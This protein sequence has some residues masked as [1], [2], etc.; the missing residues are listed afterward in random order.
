MADIYSNACLTLA[1][2]NSADSLGGCYSVANPKYCSRTWNFVGPNNQPF[3]L[4]TRQGI[5]HEAFLLRQLPL[6]S[7]GW[8]L[9]ERLLSQ[10]IIHF[11]KEE[12]VWE[13][14]QCLHCECSELPSRYF[15]DQ[16]MLLRT[17]QV[18]G[19]QY[20]D[21]WSV[22][23]EDY[24]ALALTHAR[25]IFPALQGMAK[26]HAVSLGAYHA[27]L[28]R[29]TMP[30]SLTWRSKG[31]STRPADWRAPSW[32]WASIV[33]PVESHSRRNEILDKDEGTTSYVSQLY[34][35]TVPKGHDP[36]GELVAG[37]LK[38]LARVISG[39]VI[40]TDGEFARRRRYPLRWEQP[41]S[42]EP[43]TNSESWLAIKDSSSKD[44]VTPTP[45]PS[46]GPDYMDLSLRW[47][48]DIETPGQHHVPAGSDVFLVKIIEIRK[49]QSFGEVYDEE[50]RTIREARWLIVRSANDEEDVFERVGIFSVY[51]IV[52][53]VD[54]EK[55]PSVMEGPYALA[56]ERLITII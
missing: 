48:Y 8:V 20:R 40:S 41:A 28:W 36:T 3:E 37:E 11:T 31:V 45:G 32:S 42:A 56:T 19:K 13:C 24:T 55:K 35:K 26:T 38:M 4:H 25:D 53:K 5:P 49:R 33:G 30:G 29:D 2:S 54:D 12:L 16:P 27:G 50:F 10:R 46:Y 22:I 21:K 6:M 52:A 15:F 44:Y 17:D 23:V 7:R 14:P 18:Y 1:A 51:D 47:D 34:V 9:Q 39:R 43:C